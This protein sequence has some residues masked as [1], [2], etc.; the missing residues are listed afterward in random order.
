MKVTMKTYLGE[1]HQDMMIDS[2][3]RSRSRG[4]SKLRF[5]VK[6]NIDSPL[7]LDI[8]TLFIAAQCSLFHSNTK[9]IFLLNPDSDW[10][11]VHAEIATRKQEVSKRHHTT[12]EPALLGSTAVEGNAEVFHRREGR[13]VREVSANLDYRQNFHSTASC[14]VRVHPSHG[15]LGKSWNS[16]LL[17]STHGKS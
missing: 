3:K 5:Q 4:E 6:T 2:H 11:G 1:C 8:L 15:N 14:K 9:N 12:A 13:L 16:R 7:T 17:Q 10:W